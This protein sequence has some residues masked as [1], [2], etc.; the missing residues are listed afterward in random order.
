MAIVTVQGSGGNIITIPYT[1]TQA[2]NAA[3]AA[4]TT[5]NGL[6][7]TPFFQQVSVTTN[8]VLGTPTPPAVFAGVVAST[9]GNLN[10]GILPSQYQSLIDTDSSVVAVIGGTST[11]VVVS[12]QSAKF[13]FA[14]QGPNTQVF[15]GGGINYISEAFNI[16]GGT[17]NVDASTS[18]L[19]SGAAIIDNSIGAGTNIGSGAVTVNAYANSLVNVIP[20]TKTTV[21]ALAGTV[22]LQ[23]SGGSTVPV[24]M[25]GAGGV[26]SL[27]DY[28][29]T[30]GLGFIEP[31]AENVIVLDNGIQGSTS[32]FGGNLGGTTAP[33]FTGVATVF[34][35]TG[36]FQGGSG[37]SAGTFSN[38]LE[39]STLAGAGTLVGGGGGDQLVGFGVSD[40]IVAGVGAETLTGGIGQRQ[41]NGVVAPGTGIASNPGGMFLVA[42]PGA[43]VINGDIGGFDTIST[44]T[45]T[46]TIS[47]GHSSANASI[48]TNTIKEVGVGGSETITGFLSNPFAAHDQFLVLNGVT[49]LIASTGTVAGSITSVAKLSDGTT[50]TFAN[51]FQ[52]VT[53]N[54]GT[55]A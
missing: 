21:N 2:A 15:L 48:I 11:N 46:A 52:A 22:V 6:A 44:G 25:L 12:G 16:S 55:I 20:G 14:N 47:L 1:S 7:L 29:P 40:S 43:D 38:F 53:L 24:T 36:Y 9:P 39:T 23:V 32:L 35:G 17:I 49:A 51:T 27:I 28:I 19:G 50:V 18:V 34:G 10:L 54:N 42:G 26:G 45:G 37:G 30:G 4:L 31:G 5:I 41:P 8:G 3:Q 13:I 33:T